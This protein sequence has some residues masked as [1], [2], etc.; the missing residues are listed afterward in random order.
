MNDENNNILSSDKPTSNLILKDSKL[1][2]D[3]HNVIVQTTTEDNHLIKKNNSLIFEDIK[4]LLSNVTLE[5]KKD[6]Q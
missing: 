2:C 4:E 3:E 1:P 5:V 6:N